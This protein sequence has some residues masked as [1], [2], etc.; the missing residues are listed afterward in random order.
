[1]PKRKEVFP[2]RM[3]QNIL[4]G[5]LSVA[6]IAGAFFLF[7]Q[8]E[9]ECCVCNSFRYHAPCLIDLE[10]GKLEE[11]EL[12]FPHRNKVAELADLQPE[13]HSFSLIQLG[14]VTGIKQTDIKTV[15]MDIPLSEK[16]ANPALCRKC[17][18]QLKGL[19][20][21][22]YVLAD[23][24]DHKNKTIIPLKDG[25]CLNLRCY[26]ITAQKEKDILKVTLQGNLK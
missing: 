4:S 13:M 7:Q 9:K 24:Y 2:L 15:E 16:T 3:W 12:Y 26:T 23:L 14:T 21:D 11:L 10:T 18:K 17:R 22:R 8:E 19:L 25:L 5:I 20:M 6:I 1:M